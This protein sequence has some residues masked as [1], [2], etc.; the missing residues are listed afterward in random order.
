ME[1]N[2]TNIFQHHCKLPTF[3]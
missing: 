1:I 3:P 2:S